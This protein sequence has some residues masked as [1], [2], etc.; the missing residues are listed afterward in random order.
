[1]GPGASNTE[2]ACPQ[3][4]HRPEWGGESEGVPTPPPPNRMERS[5]R[6][7]ARG[8]P[9]P[10]RDRI[11]CGM[12]DDWTSGCNGEVSGGESALKKG[13]R[14]SP[15]SVDPPPGLCGGG[16]TGEGSLLEEWYAQRGS[17]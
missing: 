9:L 4:R 6:R 3:E 10:H 5:E 15:L 11:D 14:M 16:G 1:M 13:Y 8:P 2:A 17:A 7:S 12:E